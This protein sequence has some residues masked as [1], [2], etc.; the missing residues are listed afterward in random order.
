LV[1]NI[2]LHSSLTDLIIS[3]FFLFDFSN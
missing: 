1:E 3:T 2:A